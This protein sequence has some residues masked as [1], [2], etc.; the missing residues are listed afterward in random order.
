MIWKE[1]Y[2]DLYNI[3]IQEQVAVHLYSFVG[4]GEATTSE[5]S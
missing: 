3:Y 4:F 2:E 5:E 1:Y